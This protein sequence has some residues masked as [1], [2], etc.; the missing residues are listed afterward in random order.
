MVTR[1]LS[2]SDIYIIFYL[3]TNNE[4][5]RNSH[6]IEDMDVFKVDLSGKI[7]MFGDDSGAFEALQKTAE[8]L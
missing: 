3:L 7:A 5:V 4:W 6:F 2:S 8:H 1:C